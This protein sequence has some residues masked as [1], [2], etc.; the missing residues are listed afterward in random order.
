VDERRTLKVETALMD[1]C[2]FMD[3]TRIVYRL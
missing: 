3:C 1:S 2:F